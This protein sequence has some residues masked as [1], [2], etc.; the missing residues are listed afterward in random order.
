ML[1]QM[2]RLLKAEGG[3]GLESAPNVKY[4]S[5]SEIQLREEEKKKVLEWEFDF[6]SAAS[7]KMTNLCQ[8]QTVEKWILKVG[9]SWADTPRI[10][11]P[12]IIWTEKDTAISLSTSN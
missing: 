10:R 7:W 12:S 5:G 1:L 9:L 3:G 8:M 6:V 11:K 4:K 2:K